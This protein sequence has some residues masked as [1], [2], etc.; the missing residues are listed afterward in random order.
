[1]NIHQTIQENTSMSKTRPK[2]FRKDVI[3]VIILTMLENGRKELTTKKQLEKFPIGS[4]ISYRT[5]KGEFRH[6]GFITKFESDSFIYK[7]P[8]FGKHSHRVRYSI[9][10]KMWVGGVYTVKNDFVSLV[11]DPKNPTNFPVEVGGV[12]VYYARTN[13]DRRRFMST[14]RYRVYKRWCDYFLADQ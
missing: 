6:G 4:L 3:D 1:M 12:I 14:E 2:L 5:K 9:V 10:D 13:F 11:K 7:R 8:E